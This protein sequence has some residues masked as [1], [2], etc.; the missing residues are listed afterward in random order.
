MTVH[1]ALRVFAGFMVLLSLG[2]AHFT[3][4]IDLA[5]PG[6]LWL[7]TFAGLNLFQSGFT[8]FCPVSSLFRKMGL[9]DV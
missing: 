1:S 9:K 8:N 3:G 5:R 2:L 7:T 6:W 4:Q